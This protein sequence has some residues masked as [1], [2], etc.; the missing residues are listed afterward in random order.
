M[1]FEKKSE[2]QFIPRMFMVTIL[3][4]LIV[5]A[6]CLGFLA[7]VTVVVLHHVGVF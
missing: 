2:D 7:W 4:Q 1:T 6:S 3:A 5:A